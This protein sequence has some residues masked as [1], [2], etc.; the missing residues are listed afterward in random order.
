MRGSRVIIEV[1]GSVFELALYRG[2]AVCGRRRVLLDRAEWPTPWSAGL[3]QLR[4]QLSEAIASLGCAGLPTTIVYSLPGT[5]VTVSA[6]PQV[7]GTANALQAARLALASVA[8]FPLDCNP[9]DARVFHE[10]PRPNRGRGAGN[11]EQPAD[12]ARLHTI[13]A[14]DQDAHVA[15]LGAWAESAGLKVESVVPAEAVLTA[16]AAR[17]ATCTDDRAG[18]ACHGPRAVLWMGLHQSVLAVGNGAKL[19][20]VRTIST[21]AETLVDALLRPIRP[22][23]TPGTETTTDPA[24]ITLE[25]TAARR[26]LSTVG[27]PA[28]QQQ[29]PELPG[30]DGTCILPILQPTLQRLAVEIKQS[31][32]FG[33]DESVRSGLTLSIRGEGSQ[34][35]GLTEVLA[36]LAGV[37]PAQGAG[38]GTAAEAAA[39]QL[40]TDEAHGLRASLPCLLGGEASDAM[41][42]RGMR[43][44]LLIG[45]C[46]AAVMLSFEG[47]SIF[48]SFAK[49]RERLAAAKLNAA[50]AG[51]LASVQERALNARLATSG[52]SRRVSETLGNTPDWSAVM[53]VLAEQSP[54]SIRITSLEMSAESREA[55]CHVAGY[56]RR[57]ETQDPAGEIRRFIES[58]SR[59][60]LVSSV[61][62]GVTQRGTVRGEEAHVFELSMTLVSVPVLHGRAGPVN[63][64]P[65]AETGHEAAIADGVVRP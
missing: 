15:A 31:L 3:D 36:R 57:K 58:L 40:L 41:L 17:A 46:A 35:P 54:G 43:R 61:R 23:S 26:L 4:P 55:V 27:I 12:S 33:T 25:R 21:G 28:P 20:L 62:L 64:V 44:G 10:D 1:S 45:A 6:C 13:A 16:A 5:F 65:A 37:S 59:V 48:F 38:K 18:G 34:I 47:V 51:A 29:L 11:K 50:G 24:T 14:A 49:E 39:S 7:A 22:K 53:T 52:L 30:C 2:S 8:T 60:P 32:R 56:V 63:G 42:T 19:E 9:S